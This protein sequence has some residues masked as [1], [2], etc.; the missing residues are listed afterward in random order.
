MESSDW[1]V[2]EKECNDSEGN[3]V[4]SS[5]PVKF[6]TPGGGPMLVDGLLEP[7]GDRVMEA[8]RDIG[9]N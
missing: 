9:V 7:F 4:R 2:K 1:C 8:D 5:I 3:R 6:E